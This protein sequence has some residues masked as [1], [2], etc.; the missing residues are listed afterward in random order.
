MPTLIPLVMLLAVAFIIGL[1]NVAL[2]G[3]LSVGRS[4]KVME[5][6]VIVSIIYWWYHADK[7]QRQYRAGVFLNAGV[8]ALSLIAVPIYLFRSRGATQGAKAFAFF[9]AFLAA[10]VASLVLGGAVAKQFTP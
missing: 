5:Q 1:L 2:T 6:L 3:Q 9:I 8:V 10:L 4:W 7:A